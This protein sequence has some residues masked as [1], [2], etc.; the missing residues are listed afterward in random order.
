MT[1]MNLIETDLF[2]I[3]ATA[4]RPWK[5]VKKI[6]GFSPKP[7]KTFLEYRIKY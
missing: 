5:K 6:M 4:F 7:N 3:I 1:R 2:V